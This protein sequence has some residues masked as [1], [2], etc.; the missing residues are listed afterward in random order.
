M[1]RKRGRMFLGMRGMR[2]CRHA[3][4]EPGGETERLRRLHNA[5]GER[6]RR[7]SRLDRQR[8]CVSGKDTQLRGTTTGTGVAGASAYCRHIARDLASGCQPNRT[9]NAAHP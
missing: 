6:A 1:F 7:A 9:R 4:D 2:V 8:S 5:C 3:G